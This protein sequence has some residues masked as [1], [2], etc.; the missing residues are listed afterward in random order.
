V[1]QKLQSLSCKGSQ[2]QG[3]QG[4]GDV[5]IPRSHWY[6]IKRLCQG[7]DVSDEGKVEPLVAKRTKKRLK[8]DRCFKF[9]AVRDQYTSE[10]MIFESDEQLKTLRNVLGGVC[11]ALDFILNES[12]SINIVDGSPNSQDKVRL[13]YNRNET[14]LIL[15]VQY[16]HCHS[17]QD[18]KQY[19][20]RLQ[21]I[22][23]GKV[24]GAVAVVAAVGLVRPSLR[25]GQSF[26]C[27]ATNTVL[28]IVQVTAEFVVA[29]A[30]NN[31]ARDQSTRSFTDYASVLA[32]VNLWNT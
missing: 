6:V 30:A 17:E 25:I 2:S 31:L 4:N 24:A 18:K 5:H 3:T 16:T 21:E 8:V 28:Q 10:T 27:Q 13:T 29:K 22:G 14:K 12:D 7:H 23:I 26:M 9:E 11:V 1:R 32:M 19:Q 20:T 15:A